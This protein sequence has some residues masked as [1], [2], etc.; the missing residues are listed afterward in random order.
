M[1]RRNLLGAAAAV[2]LLAGLQLPAHAD[3]VVLDFPTWQADEPGFGDYYKSAIA[4]FEEANPDVSIRLQ[5]IPFADYINQLTVRFASGRPPHILVIPTDNFGVFASQGWLKPLDDGFAEG[6]LRSDWSSLQ[7]ELT[8]D[9]QTQGMLMMGYGFMLFYNQSILDAAGIAVPTSFEEFRQAVAK[10]TNRDAGIFGLAAVT[11][12][13]PTIALDFIRFIEWQGEDLIKDDKYN[14]TDPGVV[15]AVANYR[16]TVGGNAPLGNNSTIARQLFTEGRTA[17]LIDGPWMYTTM[18]KAT[19]EV[20]PSLH[21]IRAP[22]NPVLGGASNSLHIPAGLDPEIEKHVSEF[23]SF[24]AQP[25]WQERFTQL[26]S[27]PSGRVGVL[28]EAAT[29]ASP[30]LAVI[31][32]GAVDAEPIIPN[33]KN[34]RANSAEFSAIIRRAALKVLSTQ[35]PIEG[36]LAQAQQELER[37]IPLE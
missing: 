9:G 34:I 11:T 13:H 17:F 36:I 2:A 1:L 22:F 24:L 23:L 20:R 25:A 30:Q 15:R 28:T 5:Q 32:E 16:E 31:A 4:A 6:A 14:L 12:E 21:M 35:E 8:W 26:T 29:A 37:A 10:A 27:S 7:S 3:P 19:P 33:V 18:N